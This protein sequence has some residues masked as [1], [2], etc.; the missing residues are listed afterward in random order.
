MQGCLVEMQT[1]DVAVPIGGCAPDDTRLAIGAGLR[2]RRDAACVHLEA[3]QPLRTVSSALVGGGLGQARHF[4]NFH[5]DKNYDGHDPA[6]DLR[7]WLVARDL[8]PETG[9]AMM[10]AVRLEHLAVVEQREGAFA[11][12]AA[13]TAGVSNAVDI[14]AQ[15]AGDP[16]PVIGTINIFVFVDAHL[17]DAALINACQS[18]T[19][20][21]ARA[22]HELDV[23][24]PFTGTRATGT[25]TDCLAVA[26]T[27]SGTLTHY[28]GSATLLGR[29]IGR[30][31]FDATCRSLSAGFATRPM[32]GEDVR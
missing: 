16:R 21:K 26:A 3:A 24:D 12:C 30:A 23:R 17:S 18:V 6:A 28:A 25:S 5:V 15:S 9:V 4:C 8:A 11:L 13:V 1:E 19:E 2:L 29:A 32:Q 27:Q 14:T 10:T 20:A 7:D 31:V 22:L